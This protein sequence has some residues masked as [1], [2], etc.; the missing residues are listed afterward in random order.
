MWLE[1][2]LKFQ[3]EKKTDKFGVSTN[4]ATKIYL[5]AVQC[6]HLKIVGVDMHIGSQIL[7]IKPFK[8]AFK[9]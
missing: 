6:A 5:E 3:Q 8:N 1:D 9:K 2:I 7:Q 4:E